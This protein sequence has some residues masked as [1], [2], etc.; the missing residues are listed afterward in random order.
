MKLLFTRRRH[1]SSLLIRLVTWSNFS[2]VDIVL[3]GG[4]IIGA[5]AGKGVSKG[6]F[7][8]QV[9]KASKAVTVEIPVLDLQ[10]ALAFAKSQKGKPY[11]WLGVA[12]I[13]L[14]RNW[15]EPSKWSC[16]EFV[17]ASLAKG[18]YNP[19]DAKFHHRITPQD[20]FML[21]FAKASLK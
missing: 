13:G 1:A 5:E 10:A 8:R 17:A 20:L 21:N 15:Q 3:D 7:E 16:A 12:G 11:D 2:H 9:R 18:G 19:F 6:S 14:R 4:Q